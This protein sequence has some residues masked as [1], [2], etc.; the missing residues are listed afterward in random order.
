MTTKV[1]KSNAPVLITPEKW[2][3]FIKERVH[4]MPGEAYEETSE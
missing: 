4:D 2:S 1:S 3:L